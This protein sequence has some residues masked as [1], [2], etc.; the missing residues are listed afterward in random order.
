MNA[1][2]IVLRVL[3]AA[4]AA[5]LFLVGGIGLSTGEANGLAVAL[6]LIGAGLLFLA[7]YRTPEARAEARVR[8]Q[9]AAADRLA[10]AEQARA[11]AE[12]RARRASEERQRQ[13]D[14]RRKQR[15]AEQAAWHERVRAQQQ[16]EAEAARQ[17]PPPRQ[18]QPRQEPPRQKSQREIVAERKA[19]A[20]AQG[21]ACCP[22]CGSTSLTSNKKGYGIGKGV[23]GAGLAGP[24]G[25]AAGNIGSGKVKITC[26][27][28]GRQFK[29]GK[30]RV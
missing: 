24:I 15:A 4:G 25:L 6:L 19:A 22:Y 14:L 17:A 20:A 3:A 18:E 10:A 30:G 1:L 2:R 5:F 11:D 29:P 23:I 12:R 7:F 9:A 13:E 21:I 16:A 27:N 26:L 8:R 28:C